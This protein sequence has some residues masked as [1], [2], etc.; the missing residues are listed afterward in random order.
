ML[1]YLA[2][3]VVEILLFIIYLFIFRLSTLDALKCY[4]HLLVSIPPVGCAG[5]PVCEL[6]C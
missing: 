1:I 2:S 3:K 6:P 4:T 5:D